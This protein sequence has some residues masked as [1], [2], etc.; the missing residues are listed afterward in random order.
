MNTEQLIHDTA[1]EGSNKRSDQ[2]T[3]ESVNGFYDLGIASNLL[4]GINR[5]KFKIPTPVQKKAIPAGIE[6]KDIIAIAQTGS[7]K[8][9]AFGIPMLQRLSKSK[10]GTGLV[11]VPTRE[12]AIQVDESL[13]AL[14][15]S[16]HMRSVVVIGGASMSMQRIALKKNPRII[17]ATPGRLMDHIQR[18]TV[19]LAN[20]EIFILDEADRMLDMGFI[21]DIK[22]IMKS[23]PDKRQ[24]MLFS[25]TMPKAIEAIAQKLMA[26]PTRVESD[27]SG[28]TPAEVSQEM[29]LVKNQ[30]KGQLLADHLKLCS[31][32]VLVFTRTKRMASKLTIKVNKLGFRAAEI[33]SNRSQGQRR[34]ALEGFKRGRYQILI[35]T[36]IAA[37]GIDVSGIALVVNYDMPASSE[38]YVHRIGRTGR[39]GMSGHAISFATSD[40]KRAIRD[41]ER[42]MD[43]KLKISTQPSQPSK[44]VVSKET[45]ISRDASQLSLKSEPSKHKKSSKQETTVDRSLKRQAS[46]NSHSEKF[47][48]KRISSRRSDAKRKDSEQQQSK[49][50]SSKPHKSKS[51]DSRK[52]DSKNETFYWSKFKKSRPSKKK[53]IGKNTKRK[54]RGKRK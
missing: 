53:S 49:R 30:D 35:A 52:N 29:F 40:Q 36:D 46:K 41:L 19:N 11:L 17:I 27:R 37:R 33:H 1:I 8:T 50:K 39:A 4:K 32:P 12:L 10:R 18:R 22:K 16:M 2:T 31:G 48:K 13:Q 54:N 43:T 45:V 24:T 6:G 42:F 9:L 34:N 3:R 20:I 26:D 28:V 15:R 51:G 25:A 23:I 47:A 14:G 21:P 44:K 7:G 5:L 38:D